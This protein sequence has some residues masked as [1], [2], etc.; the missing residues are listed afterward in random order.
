MLFF[1]VAL[2]MFASCG[3]QQANS[4]SLANVDSVHTVTAHYHDAKD[5]LGEWERLIWANNSTLKIK[6]VKKDS[7]YFYLLANSGGHL[8]ELEDVACLRNDTATFVAYNEDDTCRLQFVM[9]N[10]SVIIIKQSKGFC[11]AAIGVTFNGRY[12]NSRYILDNDSTDLHSL[13]ILGQ[14]QDFLFR[15]LT[16]ESYET[17]LNSSQLSNDTSDID[18]FH[19]K[20]IRSGVRGGCLPIWK[21]LL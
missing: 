5:W 4:S 15:Q 2:F 14:L 10:D 21:I 12:I 16:G 13:G 17:F 18:N 6:N 19:A 8:G 3:Q 9:Q 1:I 11:G 20:V 7:I